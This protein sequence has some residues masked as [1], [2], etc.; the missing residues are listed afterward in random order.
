MQGRKPGND[1]RCSVFD[2]NVHFLLGMYCRAIAPCMCRERANRA[3]NHARPGRNCA[4]VAGCFMLP[5]A[6]C[7]C[8]RVCVC[9]AVQIHFHAFITTESKRDEFPYDEVPLA[10][11]CAA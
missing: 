9:V 1:R 5:P 4:H 8:V 7:V 6:V 3:A 11:Q 10:Q 2:R